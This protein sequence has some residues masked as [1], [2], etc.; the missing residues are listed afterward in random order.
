MYSLV[1]IITIIWKHPII[2]KHP[3][4]NRKYKNK[5]NQYKYY[6]YTKLLVKQSFKYPSKHRDP[7]ETVRVYVHACIELARGIRELYEE[8]PNTRRIN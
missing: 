4:S 8:G 5:P 2:S 3:K 7:L 1:S 6:F